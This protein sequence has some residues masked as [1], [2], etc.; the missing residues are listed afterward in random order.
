VAAV[1][2][3]YELATIATTVILVTFAHAGARAI[4]AR[5]IDRYGDAVAGALIV[6][7]GAAM[8][9]LGI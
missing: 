9:A 6:S 1:I 7:V 4:H 8:A 2:V 3:S 5:W